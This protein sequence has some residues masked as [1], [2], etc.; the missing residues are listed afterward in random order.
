MNAPVGNK[1]K[2]QGIFSGHCETLRRF[3]DSSSL[4]GTAAELVGRMGALERRAG[5]VSASSTAVAATAVAVA[6]SVYTRRRVDRISRDQHHS[7]H[8]P[9]VLETEPRLGPGDGPLLRT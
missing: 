3:V 9:V 6:G 7:D 5:V 4:Q 1:E 8:S 2:P